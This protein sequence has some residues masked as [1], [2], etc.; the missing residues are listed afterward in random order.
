MIE[1]L[2][3]RIKDDVNGE[4]VPT[5]ITDS[6]FHIYTQHHAPLPPPLGDI[7]S[8]RKIHEMDRLGKSQSCGGFFLYV[9]QWARAR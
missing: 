4:H 3:S 9:F 1:H 8:K 7:K 5:S 2:Q 6:S